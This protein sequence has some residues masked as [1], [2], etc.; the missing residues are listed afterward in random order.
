MI[1]Y[2]KSAEKYIPPRL[3][4]DVQ[5]HRLPEVV[6]LYGKEQLLAE[7]TVDFIK[8]NCLDPAFAD[9][10]FVRLDGNAIRIDE[11]SEHL[12]T[13]PLG[14]RKIMCLDNA[15]HFFGDQKQ[16]RD[17]PRITHDEMLKLLANIPA[18]ISLILLS[19]KVDKRKTL[20]KT[21]LAKGAYEFA[22]LDRSGL[23]GFIVGRFQDEGKSVT[24]QAVSALIDLTGYLDKDSEYSLALIANDIRKIIA[25]S[26]EDQISHKDV[27]A[28]VGATINTIVFALSD[29]VSRR[30]TG[31]AIKILHDLLTGG[32]KVFSLL[33][34]IF[35]QFDLILKIRDL[36]DRGLSK[37]DIQ[38]SLGIDG[39][40][41]KILAEHASR[42]TLEQL[43]RI[44]R[45]AY[46]VDKNIKSGLL[47]DE[48]ALEMF[49]YEAGMLNE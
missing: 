23:F 46:E 15:P 47:T 32:A 4:V 36:M 18:H 41:F 10:D 34:L 40:R 8:T 13:L 1:S 24:T 37:Q 17:G 5:S 43:K 9:M 38:K 14:K 12:E 20:Y 45:S 42:F 48:L 33:G 35:S 29:A 6:L 27:A 2:T 26:T 21:A 25:Y 44:V 11:L 30:K 7:L 31:D 19:E 22:S 16:K 28:V 3:K 49:I 39:F